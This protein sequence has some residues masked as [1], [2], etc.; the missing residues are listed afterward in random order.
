[1]RRRAVVV[2][3]G[4][5]GLHPGRV[6]A[7]PEQVRLNAFFSSS[8]LPFWVADAKG[9]FGREN[10]AVTLS[11][12]PGSV[13]QFQHLSAG[14]LDLISTAFDNAISYDE[15]QVE[16]AFANPADFVGLMGFDAGF[17]QLWVR[18]EIDG[19][20]DLRGRLLAV[21]AAGSGYAFVLRAMLA[22]N[23]LGPSDYRF[24]AVGSTAQRFA[25]MQ[26][27]TDC[28]GALL[29]PPETLNA[30]AHGF[31]FLNDAADLIG[32]Y[33]ATALV[34]RRAWLERDGE[35]AV[36]FI[37]AVRSA[38]AWIF[39][40]A[41][42]EA[43]VALLAEKAQIAPAQ[44]AALVTALLDPKVGLDPDGKIDVEGVRTVLALRGTY[45]TPKKTLSD[46]LKYYDLRYYER[47]RP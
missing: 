30:K 10:L 6:E 32:H 41:N 2:A 21:D 1:M 40:P 34:A 43:A 16:A 28:V 37:R 13:Y 23:G 45:A 3:L 25:R 8:T 39:A 26:R 4:A 11:R 33:Q 15:G 42:R 38:L 9:F 29:S 47:A 18:P 17:E 7:Q 35:V 12:A 14:D 22:K 44:A 46:P 31:R 20:A 19:Y 24:E 5:A 36:R 27:G